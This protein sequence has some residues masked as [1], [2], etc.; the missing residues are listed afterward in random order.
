[1]V[2]TVPAPPWASVSGACCAMRS[3][4]PLPTTAARLRRPPAAAA[5]LLGACVLLAGCASGRPA[6]QSR[7]VSC[8]DLVAAT[9]GRVAQRLYHEAVSS[10]VTVVARRLVEQSL[11]LQNAVLRGDRRLATAAA[12][13][14]IATRHMVRVRVL[15]GA[16]V[17]ADVGPSRALAPQ[18][19]TLRGAGGQ[20]VGSYVVSTESA[21]TYVSAVHGLTLAPAVITAGR[22]ALAS[23][24]DSATPVP[25]ARGSF[26]V[27]ARRLANFTFSAEGFPGGALQVHVIPSYA[28]ARQ[29]C[30]ASER[31]TVRNLISGALLRIYHFEAS[32]GETLAQVHRVGQDEPLLRAVA[33]HDP[34]ATRRAIVALLNQHIVRLRVNDNRRLL[35]DVGGPYVLAPVTHDLVRGGQRI[36]RF[37]LSIQDDMGYLLLSRRLVGVPL[38][39]R[40]QGRTVMSALPRSPANLPTQGAFSLGGRDYE[41][42][43]FTVEAFPSG[44]LRVF[45]LIPI[46]YR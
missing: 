7:P 3:P 5:A 1:M 38:V 29:A 22:R 23:S 33:A 20:P 45:A 35:S 18:R 24:A 2:D 21:T 10:D 27:H 6:A 19:G 41:V 28:Y 42:F 15:R 40:M 39:M 36:G 32:S 9:L 31:A 16:Q 4:A 14:L 43:S 46:P 12:T 37:V 25:P 30:G 26:T 8:P 13:Q 11:P 34:A 17:L 44:P